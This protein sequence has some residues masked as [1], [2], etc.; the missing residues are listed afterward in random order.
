MYFEGPVAVAR[1]E[2]HVA[3]RAVGQPPLLVG[4]VQVGPLDDRAA[5][6]GGQVV[7]V[8]H[9]ARV[10]GLDAV[11]APA[12]VH[13]L[14]LLLVL[15]V[16]GPLGDAG[17]VVGRHVVDIQGLAAVAVDQHIRGVGVYGRRAGGLGTEEGS[18]EQQG[19]KDGE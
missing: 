11:E 9:L 7:D 4:A 1:D 15:I 6:R 5:V 17:A 10:A 19:R 3:I 18:H 13:E 16:P 12:G 8:Q 2:P 14:P